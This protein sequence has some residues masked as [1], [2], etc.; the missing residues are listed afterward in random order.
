MIPLEERFSPSARSRFT[1]CAVPQEGRSRVQ[2]LPGDSEIRGKNAEFDGLD[3]C[4]EM[5]A[6]SV[7][8]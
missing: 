3:I 2:P 8:R 6:Q 5:F 7:H 1:R 4:R